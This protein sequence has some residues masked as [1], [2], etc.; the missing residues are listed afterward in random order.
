MQ[1]DVGRCRQMQVEVGRSRKKQIDEVDEEIEG[2]EEIKMIDLGKEKCDFKQESSAI[3]DLLTFPPP[4]PPPP[5]P[6]PP[7]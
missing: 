7:Y 2:D 1:V 5:H 3:L 6:P 4:L